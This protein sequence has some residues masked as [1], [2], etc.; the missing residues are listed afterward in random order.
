MCLILCFS[1]TFD[2]NSRIVAAVWLAIIAVIRSSLILKAEA[3][4]TR[5][6]TLAA[7]GLVAGNIEW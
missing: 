5:V 6:A 1:Q 2:R 3:P 4:S 7:F